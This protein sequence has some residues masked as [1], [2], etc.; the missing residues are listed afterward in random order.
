MEVD[1]QTNKELLM[2]LTK[3]V[4]ALKTNIQIVKYEISHIKSF[5]TATTLPKPPEPEPYEPYESTGWRFLGY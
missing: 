3:E 4:K 1:K 5:L 2:E